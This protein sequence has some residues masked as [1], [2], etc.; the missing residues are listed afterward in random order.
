[1][2]PGIRL[3]SVYLFM[4]CCGAGIKI[5]ERQS[6]LRCDRGFV[7]CIETRKKMIIRSKDVIYASFLSEDYAIH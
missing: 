2:L 4:D 6:T 5:Q 1:M 7:P 3:S